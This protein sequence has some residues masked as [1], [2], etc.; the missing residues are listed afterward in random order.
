[1]KKKG[2]L[3]II[4]APS[5]SGKTTLCELLVKRMPR[6]A[7]S[8]SLT[9]RLPRRGEKNGKDYIFVTGKK[10]REKIKSGA[11]LEW[12]RNFGY[13]YGTPKD[14]VK[15]LLLGGTD[16]ILAI[17]VKGAMKV[18]KLYPDSIFIFIL[19]PSLEELKKRLKQ[20]GTDNGTEIKTRIAIAKKE[21]S[22]LP[23]Y[24]YSVINDSIKHAMAELGCI[25]KAER[26]KIGV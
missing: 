21:I 6:L 14:K 19:P 17:D 24:N 20:R 11:L 7:R 1:M 9:T 23:V 10:F 2:T 16:V 26:R 13:Y 25:I 8:V 5:G 15:K 4:S 12:A 18:R 22:Y 3:F